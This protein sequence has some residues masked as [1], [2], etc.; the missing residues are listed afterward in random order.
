[1][2]I[3]QTSPAHSYHIERIPDNLTLSV[4]PKP[5]M[6][7]N[8]CTIPGSPVLRLPQDPTAHEKYRSM[9]RQP[10]CRLTWEDIRP[11]K[12]RRESFTQKP[13]AMSSSVHASILYNQAGT[14]TGIAN[15]SLPPE[16]TCHTRTGHVFDDSVTQ[17]SSKDVPSSM[18]EHTSGLPELDIESLTYY[19]PSSVYSKGFA[20]I[21]MSTGCDQRSSR[22]KM[23]HRKTIQFHSE[24]SLQTWQLLVFKSLKSS[25]ATTTV[26]AVLLLPF[27]VL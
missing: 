3:N 22:R 18:L 4:F 16:S 11:L 24:W 19:P 21:D 2:I 25:I 6:Q 12:K 20:T 8:S 15:E 26:N 1:M 27:C 10:S 13:P 23:L 5:S 9:D 17:E 7:P 14:A